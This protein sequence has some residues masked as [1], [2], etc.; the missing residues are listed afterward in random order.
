M[1]ASSLRP[2]TKR[3]LPLLIWG[4]IL[5]GLLAFLVLRVLPLAQAWQQTQR[6]VTQLEQK[7]TLLKSEKEMAQKRLETLQAEFDA[8][9]EPFLAEER[10]LLPKNFDVEK[11]SKVL[12]Q[13]SLQLPLLDPNSTLWI[14][15]LSFSQG[16]KEPGEKFARTSVSL[17]METTQKDLRTFL[18]FLQNGKLTEDFEIGKAQGR[19]S[20]AVYRY[21][22]EN[23]L[24]LAHIQSIHISEKQDS[25]L[26]D[27]RLQVT[28]FSQE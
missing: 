24:P 4:L 9:A 28:F 21:L 5:I 26:I 15:N 8:A 16:R 18:D 13:Y 17:T 20:P 25:D 1:N 23:L 19:I 10:Q 7:V 22:T 12:E 27:A 14:Q 6:E 3:K 11:V 2:Q